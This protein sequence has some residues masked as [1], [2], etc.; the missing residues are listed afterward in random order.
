MRSPDAPLPEGS[1]VSNPPPISQRSRRTEGGCIGIS[2]RA[3]L[4]ACAALTLGLVALV[5]GTSAAE[6]EPPSADA[7]D[8][9]PIS[10]ESEGPVYPI[11]RFAVSYA[12]DHPDQPPLS[13][14]LPL[15]VELGRLESG[16]TAPHPELPTE[17]LE[18]GGADDAGAVRH[19]HAT[20][21]GSI[22]QQL[23]RALH[24]R[25]LLG[26]YVAPHEGDLDLRDERDLRPPDNT[27]LR[28]VIEASRVH[29]VRTIAIGDRVKSSWVIDNA[30]HRPIRERSPIQPAGAAT[31]DTTDLVRKDFLEDYL[32]QLNRHPGRR[33]EA[34]LSAAPEGQGA[35]LDYRVAEA[36]PWFAYF[37]SSNT[38]SG[39]VP[40]WQ[41]R[42]GFVHNQVTDRDDILRIEYLNAGGDDLNSL[43]LTYEAPWFSRQRPSWYRSNPDRP[44]WLAWLNPD[45]LPWFG[46]DR[47]RWQLLGSWY[48]FR[49][50]ELLDRSRV[51]GDEWAAGGRLRYS[52]FQHR[53]LFVDFFAGYRIRGVSTEN[54]AVPTGGG[55][56]TLHIPGA[57]FELERIN[58]YSYLR[59]IAR[60]DA[61]VAAIDEGQLS[62]LGAGDLDDKWHALHWDFGFTTYLE[63]LLNRKAW[64][65]P[66][67]AWSSTL[68]HE[69][70]LGLRGQYGF[71][72]R[73][74]PQA[75]QVIGGLYT[76]RGY[77]GSVAT[78]DS[79]FLGS[80]EYRF[81]LPH[82]LPVRRKPSR[83]P[84]LGDFRITPQQAYGRPDWDLVIRAF[85][86]AGYAI[87]NKRRWDATLGVRLEAPNTLLGA[88]LGAELRL[89]HNLSL[90]MDWGRALKST[91]SVVNDPVK[92]GN[93]EFHFLFSVLY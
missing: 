16:Y 27:E 67:T 87:R 24:Q 22:T 62:R 33:V 28:L 75:A 92:A 82:S 53:A 30:I 50:A 93:N 76:V 59:G 74:I 12:V 79:V 91:R 41:Q 48:R 46:S 14:I 35:A 21:I 73:M 40:R 6:G 69:L 71:D 5:G 63:P 51:D 90:R 42:F 39:L 58:E 44:A 84:L 66:S 86:D 85:V 29:Q 89:R 49:S 80:V 72:Y 37:R 61:N 88:G 13:R 11:S 9:A 26:V 10:A 57:G 34:A 47:L 78:G 43:Y 65:N 31:G 70:A 23:L 55:R 38:G 18:I 7:A 4:G 68:A 83:V 52:L 45:K 8:F 20:A 81:H 54:N 3:R 77:P 25:Y 1:F 56:A 19:F 15:R 36:K 2:G 64:Q 17:T 32:F 60:W